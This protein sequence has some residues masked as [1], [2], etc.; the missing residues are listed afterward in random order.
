[1]LLYLLTLATGVAGFAELPWWSAV[2]GACIISLLLFR[3]DTRAY[4]PPGDEA[5]WVVAETISNMLIGAVAGCLAFVIGRLVA[6]LLP[7]S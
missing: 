1:M 7:L 6:L 5:S 2:A 3:E 4:A